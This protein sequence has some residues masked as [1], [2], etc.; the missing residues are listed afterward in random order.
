M[1]NKSE[2]VIFQAFHNQIGQLEFFSGLT[3]FFGLHGNGTI[4]YQ[5]AAYSIQAG[6]LLVVNPFELYQIDCSENA[7]IIAMQIPEN[8]LQLAGWNTQNFVFCYASGLREKQEYDTIRVLF[9]T[10]FQDFFQNQEK[11]ASIIASNLLKLVNL[12]ATRFLI[13]NTQKTGTKRE[14]TMKRMKRIM[15]YIHKNWNEDISLR[16]LAEQEFLSEGY[17]SRFLK[18]NLDMTYS[19]Y[20]ISLRLQHAEK[21]LRN[22]NHSITQVAYDC[23][24]HNTSS[25]I[26]NFRQKYGRTPGQYRKQ[27]ADKNTVHQQNQEDI[28]QNGFAF[29]LQFAIPPES[30]EELPHVTRYITI[31]REICPQK[32]Q[33]TWKTLLNAGYAKYLLT[34]AV[35]QQIIKIQQEIGFRYLRFHG[36]L[37]QAL[38]IYQG[39]EN[40]TVKCC[41]TY[42][43][44][45]IDFLLEQGL[46]PFLEFSFLPSEL[47]KEPTSIFETGS[48]TAACAD[49][50]TFGALIQA[51]LV[52]AIHRYGWNEVSQWKFTTI[53]INYVFFGCMTMPEY[54]A[55]YDCVYHAVKGIHSE[56]QF[57]GPGAISSVLWDPRGMRAFLQHALEQQCLPDF[58]CVQSYPHESITVDANF[59]N[60]T[61]NQ[62]SIPS[63]LSKDTDFVKTFLYDLKGMFQEFQ[64]SG[65]EVFIEEWNSTLWQRDLSSDTCYKSVWFVKNICENMDAAASFGYWTISD[66]MDERSDFDTLYHG[67]YGLFTYN[68]IPKSGYEAMRLLNQLGNLFV[69]SGDGWYLT[70]T[71][72]EDAWQL[73]LYNYSHYDNIYRYR[74]RKLEHAA[75]AYSVFEA[76]KILRFQIVLS[77]L[78]DG[79]YQLERKE[80]TRT[81]GSSFDLWLD[82]GAPKAPDRAFIQYLTGHAS[83][84]CTLSTAK[85]ENGLRLEETLP[86]LAVKLI[87]MKKRNNR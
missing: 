1:H 56:L 87:T 35:Q 86:P 33:H 21:Q 67:G 74:Y 5:S 24:F 27:S 26:D 30:Q 11:N 69:A 39:K 4:R 66:L 57:G 53:Q 25:F 15:D 16:N 61:L 52:H 7:E 22:T 45:V 83:P 58:I 70:K 9:A 41:F 43:D 59:M 54:L 47:A 64:L 63:V 51:I 79:I 50:E 17:L 81:S 2:Q 37:D 80:I 10:I 40:D 8:F 46:K 48:I 84:H 76:G 3:L 34:A 78:E 73:I 14:E 29:L 71:E 32:I 75:E 12:L 55:L 42:F 31:D 20:V 13:S 77:V 60:Y 6:A 23:G 44:M 72:N 38:H 19:Q 82:A 18:Q 68:G 28:L 62:Q 36:I 85:A 49:Y 65:K